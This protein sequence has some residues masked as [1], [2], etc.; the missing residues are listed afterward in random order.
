LKKIVPLF[1][2]DNLITIGFAGIVLCVL[3]AC[4]INHAYWNSLP[5]E[6]YIVFTIVGFIMVLLSVCVYAVYNEE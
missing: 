4:L 5:V 3:G 1:S 6:I 2:P